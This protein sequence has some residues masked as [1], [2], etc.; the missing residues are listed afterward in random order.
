VLSAWL[1]RDRHGTPTNTA[2]EEHDDLRWFGLDELPPP[3]DDLVRAALLEAVRDR[4]A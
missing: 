4:H 1:V 3:A 2:P